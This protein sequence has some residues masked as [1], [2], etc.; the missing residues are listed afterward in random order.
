M[1][2]DPSLLHT[3]SH[4]N[5]G[6]PGIR[7]F[8]AAVVLAGIT[9]GVTGW[10]CAHLLHGVE[11][12]VWSISEGHLV[13]ALETVP[14]WRRFLTL[15][16]AGVIGA[17]SWV[18]L[19]RTGPGP[20]STEQAVA[21]RRMPVLRTIWHSATQ[22]VIIA[23]GASLGREVAPRE[24]GAALSGWISDR[25]GLDEEDRRILVACG[26]GAGL[27]AVYGIPL[28]G[29]SFSKR[30]L[31]SALAV[32]G[33]A[34]F[35]STGWARPEVY[36]RM[37]ELVSSPALVAWAVLCGPVIGLAG[38]LFGEAV[39][40]AE[41]KRPTTTR[42]LWVMPLGFAVVGAASI[43]V[44]WV[45]GNGHPV[46]QT[47]TN[48]VAEVGPQA[49]GLITVLLLAKAV[50]TLITVR[51]GAWGGTLNPGIALGA[52]LGGMTGLVWSLIW[53]GSN[54][55]ACVFIGAAAFLGASIKAPLTGF[56]LVLELTHSGATVLVP[57]ALAIAGATAV[58]SWW[59][60]RG[61]EHH[62]NTDDEET[63][64]VALTTGPVEKAM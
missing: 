12:F 19:H 16:A 23:M 4:I 46:T 5:A 8:A 39:T 24:A 2:S 7:R 29:I 52:A 60:N 18:F 1:S 42:L 21:G 20:V 35:V 22:I 48:Q 11:H 10:A 14:W 49:L 26:A 62:E 37:P 9:A 34:V 17:V 59:R 40:R 27:A 31:A 63:G 15:V 55:V 56:A 61:K 30:S 51:V 28:S 53:P 50:T 36:Y 45:L 33:I 54:L 44:P 58:A 6:A 25:F 57:T 43:W 32:S 41:R 3:T 47:V 38:A 64:P 13:T